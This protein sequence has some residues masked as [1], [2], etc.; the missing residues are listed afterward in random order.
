MSKEKKQEI[1]GKLR[2]S[3]VEKRLDLLKQSYEEWEKS[4]DDYLKALQVN[5][6][7]G[8]IEDEIEKLV[9]M[10][11]GV[12]SRVGHE[13]GYNV[14]Y[15]DFVETAEQKLRDDYLRAYGALKMYKAD[16]KKQYEIVKG[17]RKVKV[18]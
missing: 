5:R 7:L 13:V 14:L 10:R 12:E 17:F 1:L 6:D 3:F 15:S 4:H 2:E 11:Q 8:E 18:F 9:R 16:E